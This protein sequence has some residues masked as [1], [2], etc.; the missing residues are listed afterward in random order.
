MDTDHTRPAAPTWGSP[1]PHQRWGTRQTTAA[2]AVAAAIAAVGGAAIFA[3]SGGASQVA[4]PP[5][6]PGFGPPGGPPGMG[7]PG[8]AAPG[9]PHARPRSWTHPP[10]DGPARRSGIGGPGR[11]ISPTLSGC[12]PAVEPPDDPFPDAS[13]AQLRGAAGCGV[14]PDVRADVADVQSARQPAGAQ[15]ASA[16][17][18]DRRQ[19]RRAGPRQADSGPLR[20]L[21]VRRGPRRLR[22]HRRRPAG[23]RRAVA[24]H[25][26][27]PEAGAHRLG[28]RHRRRRRGGRV[29][30][31]PSVPAVRPGHHGAV[32]ADPVGPHLR[33]RQP[34]DPGGAEGQHHPRGAGVRIHRE[35]SP[36][37]SGAPGTGSSTACNT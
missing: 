7:A 27:E 16:A 4:G 15:P 32:A 21:G 29:G 14:V 6:A 26:G 12:S 36:M 33:D 25:R 35:T 24:P 22:H 19:G 18:G 13:A 2:V 17:V 9:A 20:E 5:G 30:R 37:R 11:G 8:M 1:Q 3:A 31:D 23:Q 34:V 28:P 10:A